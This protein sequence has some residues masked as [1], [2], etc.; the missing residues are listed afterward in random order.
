MTRNANSAILDFT[1]PKGLHFSISKSPN[2]LFRTSYSMCAVPSL[3]GSV[4]YI[5]T[6]RKLNV[7]SSKDVNFKDMIDRF[8]IYD[9][10][11]RPEVKGSTYLTGGGTDTRGESSALS[12]RINDIVTLTSRLQTTFCTVASTYQPEDWMLYTLS[13]YRRL[14]RV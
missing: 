4:G 8:R 7:K 1:V 12:T 10:P 3:N 9:Q 14:S 11:R 2:A 13:G 5:F 6:S